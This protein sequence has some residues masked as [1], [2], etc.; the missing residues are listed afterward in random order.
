M[1]RNVMLA[2][3]VGFG[4]ATAVRGYAEH[5]SVQACLD[6]GGEVLVYPRP[7][8][9]PDVWICWNYHPIEESATR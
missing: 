4:F 9:E 1:M 6:L 7:W 8:S 2:F 5:Q 3:L